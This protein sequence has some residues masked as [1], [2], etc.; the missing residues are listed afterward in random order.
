MIRRSILLLIEK[1]SMKITSAFLVQ[2]YSDED[3]KKLQLLG[4]LYSSVHKG[5]FLTLEQKEKFE[6]SN[7]DTSILPT[8]TILPKGKG[9]G[10]FIDDLIDSWKV[11]GDTFSKKDAIKQLGGK[12]NPSDKS[13]RIPRE[14]VDRLALEAS[15][16]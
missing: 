15:L 4:A 12:W 8:P 9:I 3:K 7:T 14:K 6:R 10:I 1:D 16:Q 2:E 11:Y 5:W 13:W